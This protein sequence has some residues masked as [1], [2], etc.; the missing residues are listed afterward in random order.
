MVNMLLMITII[1]GSIFTGYLT[2]VV[3]CYTKLQYTS[4][5]INYYRD[6]PAACYYYSEF[7]PQWGHPFVVVL[8]KAKLNISITS[9]PHRNES[10]SYWLSTLF[11][12]AKFSKY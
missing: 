8:H 1:M 12:S 10:D 3:L 7:N 9:L 4:S 5:R 2:L 6:N 11:T